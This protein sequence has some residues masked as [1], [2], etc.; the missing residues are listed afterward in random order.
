ML[1]DMTNI[2]LIE[3]TFE[4]PESSAEAM[5]LANRLQYA[6]DELE[7]MTHMMALLEAPRG[8]DA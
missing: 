1:E 6:V 8:T 7:R 3:F 2:E 4:N 5:E